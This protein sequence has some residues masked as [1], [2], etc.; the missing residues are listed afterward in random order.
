ML[1]HNYFFWFAFWSFRVFCVFIQ[2]KLLQKEND[3]K[4]LILTLIIKKWENV[5]TCTLSDP[6]ISKQECYFV[7]VVFK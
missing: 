6:L 4:C 1:L 3:S 5:C 7:S 2:Q